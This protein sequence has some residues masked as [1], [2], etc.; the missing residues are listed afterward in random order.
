METTDPK[1]IRLRELRDQSQ[2]G[3]GPDK[4]AAQRARG[5]LTA[6]DRI[7]LFLD[8]GSFIETDALIC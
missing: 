1:T 2:Q 8:K 5:R 7:E 3:G 4:I 6:R